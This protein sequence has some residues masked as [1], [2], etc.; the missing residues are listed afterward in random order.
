MCATV[1]GGRICILSES[2]ACRRPSQSALVTLRLEACGGNDG[3]CLTLGKPLISQ[4]ATSSLADLQRHLQ[5]LLSCK[6][7]RTKS[8]C[9]EI[10]QQWPDGADKVSRIGNGSCHS[11]MLL[12]NA[13][14]RAEFATR[15]TKTVAA[16]CFT[17]SDDVPRADFGS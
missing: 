8:K 1:V 12:A 4:R 9:C 14:K 15:L 7:E 13:R 6:S 3:G 16:A 2:C 10:R 17:S 5:V 11:L